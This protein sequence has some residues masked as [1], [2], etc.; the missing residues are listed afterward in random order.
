MVIKLVVDVSMTVLMLVV[1]AYHLTGILVHEVVGVTLLG[2][3]IVHNILNRR[4]YKTILKGTFNIRR[5]LSITVNLLFLVSMVAVMVSSV[6]ISREVLTFIPVNNDM[7]FMQIHV[8][9][10]YWGF[11]FMAIHIG[12]S[13]ATIMNAMRKMTGITDPSRIRA[14][15]LRT[16]AVLIVVYGVQASFERN[17][18][19]KLTVYDPF[20]SW[21]LEES[22]LNF[23]MDYLSVMGIYICGTH[24]ALKFVQKKKKAY[25]DLHSRRN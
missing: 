13:W 25:R 2:L 4:W 17:L 1:M 12:M 5:V 8:M 20:G 7:I 18:G 23:L 6:P 14:L 21:N 22:S 9:T 3:F 19:S 11:I 15:S 16:V 10:S 24:Y